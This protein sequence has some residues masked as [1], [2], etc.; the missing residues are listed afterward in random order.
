MENEDY[1]MLPA[2]KDPS[3]W[4][5]LLNKHEEGECKP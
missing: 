1:L 5:E 3:K 4:Q 2:E